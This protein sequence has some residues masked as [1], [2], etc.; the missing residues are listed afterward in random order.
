LLEDLAEFHEE[1]KGVI[2][3]VETD[4]QDFSDFEKDAGQE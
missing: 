1:L 4:C 3:S 2:E